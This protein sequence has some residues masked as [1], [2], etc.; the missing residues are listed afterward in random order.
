MNQ[1]N[2]ILED[3]AQHYNLLVH[4]HQKLHKQIEDAYD[5]HLPD[6]TIKSM[7]MNKLHLKDEL[8]RLKNNLKAYCS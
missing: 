2:R 4:Q 1:T 5:S 6:H 7:K 8:E 3:V